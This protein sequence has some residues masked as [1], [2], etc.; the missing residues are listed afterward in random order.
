MGDDCSVKICKNSCSGR[1][2]CIDTNFVV[3]NKV[4][5]DKIHDRLLLKLDLPTT[6]KFLE[7]IV[8]K[9][10]G[11]DKNDENK[12][13]TEVES[14]ENMRLNP[15][16]NLI[17]PDLFDFKKQFKCVCQEGYSGDDCSVKTC[18]NQCSGKGTCDSTEKENPKCICHAGFNGE[19]CEKRECPN[20]CNKNGHCNH[21][22][23]VCSCTPI[24][25]GQDCSVPKCFFNCLDKGVCEEGGICNCSSGFM[26]DVC[27]KL[28]CPNE[29][30]SKGKCIKGKCSCDAGW[31][32]TDCSVRSCPNECTSL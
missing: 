17:K 12:S 4:Y 16:Q 5:R 11:K 30:S 22:N 27:E 31:L 9:Q 26:G 15:G 6:K 8:K 28:A 25:Q 1:G 29:C 32:G 18:K 19:I 24:W 21:L 14:K 20:D 3:T 13:I 2:L 10:K 7:A 23:G